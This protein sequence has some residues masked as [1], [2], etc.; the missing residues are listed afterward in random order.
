MMC[1]HCNYKRYFPITEKKVSDTTNLM[2]THISNCFSAPQSVKASLCYLQH[3]SLIQKSRFLMGNW[4]ITFF[5]RVWNRLHHEKWDD[6]PYDD[7]FLHVK[8]RSLTKNT[9]SDAK[10][11][12]AY[13]AQGCAR[14]PSEDDSPSGMLR[15]ATAS[16]TTGLERM[17]GL[18]HA[19]AL[20][21]SEQDANA[22]ARA[23]ASR[24]VGTR[25]TIR[26]RGSGRGR[27]GRGRGIRRQLSS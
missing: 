19:A 7:D 5:K 12:D 13:D 20:W 1:I 9:R 22:E 26:P 17:R 23:R 24:D 10:A 18:I 6:G 14:G 16:N 8:S 15:G 2:M 21:L 3:R 25:Q 27:N 11:G 4:K